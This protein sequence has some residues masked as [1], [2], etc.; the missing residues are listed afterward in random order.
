[1]ALTR[2]F[3]IITISSLLFSS[4]SS[5]NAQE[6]NKDK[7]VLSPAPVTSPTTSATHPFKDSNIETQVTQ[8]ATEVFDNNGNPHLQVGPVEVQAKVNKIEKNMMVTMQKTEDLLKVIKK[9]LEA[10]PGE[11]RA[12]ECLKTC[13]EVYEE[14][15]DDI[16][17]SIEDLQSGNYYKVNVDISAV[18]TDVD[19]CEECYVEM[20]GEDP[21]LKKFDEWVK[22][23]TS[24]CLGDLESV[25]N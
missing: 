3:L 12:E 17:N 23:V 13:I 16:K 5:I 15:I 20:L 1:M 18:S 7:K 22:G 14:A 25:S 24:E 4:F 10:T 6:E 9:R 21:E 8:T 11:S 2:A 19:T